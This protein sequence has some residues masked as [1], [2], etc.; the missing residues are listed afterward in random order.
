M[1]NP[2]GFVEFAEQ[3]RKM[4][5]KIA[6]HSSSGNTAEW[7]DGVKQDLTNVASMSVA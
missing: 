7:T 5:C 6:A 2:F 3:T 1:Y 4:P